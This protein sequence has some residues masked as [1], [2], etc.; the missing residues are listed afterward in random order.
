M[1]RNI[2]SAFLSMLL[3]ST[4]AT[5]LAQE[6]KGFYVGAGYGVIAVPDVEGVKFSDANNAYI[7]VGYSFSENFAIEGQYSDSTKDASA[8]LLIENIDTTYETWAM[9]MEYN[10]ELT[11][12]QVASAFPATYA[13]IGFDFTASIETTAL[14]GVYRTS[15][16]FY[17][18]AKAGAISVDASLTATPDYYAFTWIDGGGNL[19]EGSVTDK[20]E[21][22][23]E[24]AREWRSTQSERET[25][26][27]AGLGAGYKFGNSFFA[28][29]EYTRVD[30]DLDYYSLGINYLF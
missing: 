8:R 17:L 21:G 22:F 11:L 14:Y 16:D 19:F 18:K 24:V 1:A 27:S 12:E 20:D 9:L 28:E 15:G 7:Q 29:L 6:K 3:V 4:A 23:G 13:D 25:E 26:F 2:L 5:T 10:P 30:S